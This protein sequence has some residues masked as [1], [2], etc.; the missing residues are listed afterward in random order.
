MVDRPDIHVTLMSGPLDGQTFVFQPSITNEPLMVSIGRREGCDIVLNYD[1]QVSRVH[2]HVIY[3]PRDTE[4]FLEDANSRNGTFLGTAQTRV[5]ERTPIEPG[6][7]F[8]I[9]RTWL[10]LDPLPDLPDPTKDG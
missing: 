5:R 8:K 9:G 2:A 4:F 7:F 10:R 3:D 1:A 6:T